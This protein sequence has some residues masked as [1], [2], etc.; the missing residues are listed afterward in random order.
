MKTK[1]AI[2]TLSAAALT[3]LLL[4]SFLKPSAQGKYLTV[5]TIEVFNGIWD[6]KI[7]ILYEDGKVE[8]IELEKFRS[9]NFTDNSKKIHDAI[10]AVANKGYTLISSSSGTGD[11][12]II[13]S[14]IF[15]RN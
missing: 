4:S 3:I 5:R 10:N 12:V 2:L 9:R 6:S 14:F 8:E 1:R 15:T 7:V 13:S 11:A